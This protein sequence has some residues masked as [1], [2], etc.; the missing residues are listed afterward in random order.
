MGLVALLAVIAWLTPA[1]GATATAATSVAVTQ[2]AMDMA[3]RADAWTPADATIRVTGDARVIDVTVTPPGAATRRVHVGAPD[4]YRLAPG[5]FDGTGGAIYDSGGTGFHPWDTA[6]PVLTTVNFT[7]QGGDCFRGRFEIKDLAYGA[8]GRV[9]RLWLVFQGLC[10]VGGAGMLGEVRWNEPAGAADG[11]IPSVAR[12]P[13]GDVDVPPHPAPVTFVAD[14][15]TTVAGAEIGGPAATE[16]SV[17]RDGCTGRTLAAGNRCQVWVQPA[18]TS[19]GT[20][21]ATLRLET[22]SGPRAADLQAFFRGGVTRLDIQG[23]FPD[24]PADGSGDGQWSYE[25]LRQVSGGGALTDVGFGSTDGD[26]SVVLMAAPYTRLALGAGSGQTTDGPRTQPD[27]NVIGRATWCQPGARFSYYI[28]ELTTEAHGFVVSLDMDFQRRCT[29]QEPLLTGRVQLRAG[30]RTP[31]APWMAAAPGGG[32][33]L[34]TAVPAVAAGAPANCTSKASVSASPRRQPVARIRRHGLAVRGK[35]CGPVVLTVRVDRRSAR[36]L[37]LHGRVLARKR[38]APHGRYRTR[39]RLGRAA[40]R[41]IGRHRGRL[42]ARVFLSGA[43]R[44]SAVAL[45]R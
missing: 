14:R 27:L 11:L 44:S 9:D 38:I 4:G 31:R 10:G 28:H 33:L 41:A 3:D 39:I 24:W 30:D 34:P 15:L 5:V 16:W 21:L 12:W 8:D 26:W 6:A 45:R 43:A 18:P 7:A 42:V 37:K 29:P 1:G 40:R 25:G 20:H 2:L 23:D 17:S 13:D 22:S 35:A 36:R 32:V 19:P